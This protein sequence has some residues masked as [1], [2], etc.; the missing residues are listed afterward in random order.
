MI[1][2]SGKFLPAEPSCAG[3]QPRGQN[4]LRAVLLWQERVESKRVSLVLDLTAEMEKTVRLEKQAS[5]LVAGRKLEAQLQSCVKQTRSGQS[6]KLKANMSKVRFWNADGNKLTSRP[7]SSE[8]ARR[9]PRY[10]AEGCFS[11]EC[12]L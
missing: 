9:C 6:L 5:S 2:I 1:K 4:P 7:S 8:V 10:Q 12:P 3:T 11:P